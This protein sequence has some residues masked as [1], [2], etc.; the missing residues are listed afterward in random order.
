MLLLYTPL[1]SFY[2]PY[3]TIPFSYHIHLFHLSPFLTLLLFL[4]SLPSSYWFSS[5][6]IYRSHS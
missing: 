5:S 1:Y 4:S 3:P 2:S 6:F